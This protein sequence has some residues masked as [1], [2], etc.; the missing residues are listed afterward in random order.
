[1]GL[2]PRCGEPIVSGLAPTLV[3]FVRKGTPS[4]NLPIV[5][6]AVPDFDRTRR[7]SLKLA[8]TSTSSFHGVTNVGTFPSSFTLSLGPVTLH[9]ATEGGRCPCARPSE[10]TSSVAEMM[11]RPRANLPERLRG[12]IVERDM[13][14]RYQRAR[15]SPSAFGA[16]TRIFVETVHTFYTKRAAALGAPGPKTGAVTVVQRTS[17]DLLLDPHLHVIFL[18][19][20]YREQA[21]HPN[22]RASL[23]ATRSLAEP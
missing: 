1:M 11:T 2:R 14:N 9:T 16:L 6:G 4:R 10:F 21:R 18:D 5:R 17:S 15:A 19:G 3:V 20:S 12:R 23:G 22:R 8:P 7:E 13:P